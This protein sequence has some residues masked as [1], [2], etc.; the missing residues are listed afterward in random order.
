M[1]KSRSKQCC[2]HNLHRHAEVTNI[3]TRLRDG[4]LDVC[5]C[6]VVSVSNRQQTISAHR[7][8]SS[9]PSNSGESANTQAR[10]AMQNKHCKFNCATAVPTKPRQTCLHTAHAHAD[11]SLACVIAG[12]VSRV[13]LAKSAMHRTITAHGHTISYALSAARIE[14]MVTCVSSAANKTHHFSS[15]ASRCEPHAARHRPTP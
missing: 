15:A 10:L 13:I 2:V 9:D 5:A 6:V 11:C 1:F 3:C 7:V 8:Q 4:C 14:S 12:R